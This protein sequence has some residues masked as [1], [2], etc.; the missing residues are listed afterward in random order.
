M[1]RPDDGTPRLPDG[2]PAS[3]AG[4]LPRSRRGLPWGWLLAGLLVLLGVAVVAPRLLGGPTVDGIGCV[5][6]SGA[7]PPLHQHLTIEDA[8]RPILVP[9]GI[10]D[11]TGHPLA[12]CLYWLHTHAADG[13]IHIESPASRTYTLGQFFAVWRQSLGLASV[14]SLRADATH[15]I[16]TYVNGRLYRADPRTLPLTQRARITLSRCW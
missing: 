2:A 16:R 11:D 6:R 8:G 3:A 1:S 15:R 12:S 14:L 13:I 9:G 10:G 4:E 5:P 7:V